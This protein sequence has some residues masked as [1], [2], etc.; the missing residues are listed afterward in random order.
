MRPTQKLIARL[1]QTESFSFEHVLELRISILEYMNHLMK[2]YIFH[3]VKVDEV[4]ECIEKLQEAYS[5]LQQISKNNTY[6]LRQADFDR[7]KHEIL[8]CTKEVQLILEGVM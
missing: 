7:I 1:E 3:N 4:H 6:D 8:N 2:E 5:T